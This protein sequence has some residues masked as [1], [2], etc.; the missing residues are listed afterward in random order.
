L[1][2]SARRAFKGLAYKRYHHV[3]LY[4]EWAPKSVFDAVAAPTTPA[5]SDLQARDREP[6]VNVKAAAVITGLADAEAEDSEGVTLYVKN[7][8]FG[9]SAPLRACCT[10]EPARARCGAVYTSPSAN[11]G[12]VLQPMSSSRRTSTAR[13]RWLAARCARRTSR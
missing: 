5:A 7:L 13:R 8:S 1:T 11:G 2:Q 6:G 9:T 3:P 12:T 4:L 10:A